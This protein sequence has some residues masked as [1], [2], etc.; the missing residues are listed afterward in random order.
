MKTSKI[1][2][3]NIILLLIFCCGLLTSCTPTNRLAIALGKLSF[4]SYT[5]ET[6]IKILTGGIN[7]DSSNL[8][9]KYYIKTKQNLKRSHTT[10]RGLLVSYST[11]TE[12]KGKQIITYLETK[13][14]WELE[15]ITEGN[16]LDSNN[17]GYVSF[18][19]ELE[20]DDLFIQD[21]DKW[22]GNNEILS[23]EMENVFA[24]F[25]YNILYPEAMV[26]E[27]TVTKYIITLNKYNVKKIEI[28]VNVFLYNGST[29][30]F[31]EMEMVSKY[32]DIGKTKVKRPANLN[33]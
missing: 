11:Y 12:K 21:G 6:D 28:A 30:F 1:I 33:K 23:E 26:R 27:V 13:N 25:V 9:I 32:K 10:L 16:S 31:V 7:T 8:Q 14:G 22:I 24:Q 29:P 2:K 4:F 15:S 20:L 3:I 17:Y 19:D 5:S 18:D